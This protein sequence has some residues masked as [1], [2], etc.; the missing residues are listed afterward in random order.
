ML[1]WCYNVCIEVE[2]YNC[3]EQNAQAKAQETSD[4]CDVYTV[5]QHNALDVTLLSSH[6]TMWYTILLQIWQQNAETEIWDALIDALLW[7]A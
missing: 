2:Y 5:T 3:V 6:V 7:I 1:V 4:M